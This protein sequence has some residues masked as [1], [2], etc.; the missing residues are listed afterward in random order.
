MEKWVPLMDIFLSS[1]SPEA[2]A[3]LW[4]QR[5][6]ASPASF[7]S[8]LTKPFDATVLDSSSSPSRAKRVMW[9]QTLPNAV[10]TRILSFL[11]FDHQRFSDRELSRLARNI[12]IEKPEID[13]WVKKTATNLLDIISKKDDG[14]GFSLNLKR[15]EDEFNSLPAWLKIA[16]GA[17]NLLLPWLPL[18]YDEL[19]LSSLSSPCK[20]DDTVALIETTDDEMEPGHRDEVRAAIKIVNSMNASALNSGL[21]KMAACLKELIVSSESKSKTLEIANEIRQ[22]CLDRSANDPLSLLSL[23]EPWRA[24]DEAISFLTLHLLNGIEDKV[25]WPSQILCSIILPKLLVLKEPASRVLLKTTT[26]CCKLHQRAAE[27]ALL[28]PLIL[29]SEGINNHMCDVIT[30]IIRECLHTVHVS[31]FCQKLLS[32]EED[33]WNYVCLP[34]HRHLISNELVW[35]ESL[36]N[37]F[38]NILN[39]NV[40]LTQDSVD[41]L[42]CRAHELT[43]KFSKSLKF[44]KFLLCLLTK[45]SPFLKSHKLV[46]TEAVEKTDTIMTKAILAKLASL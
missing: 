4:L 31:S 27:Y 33:D 11:A 14:T 16:A 43:G 25:V 7:L 35:T 38:Q 12:L 37:L 5:S 32:G 13:F 36:L 22:L 1:P 9:I 44:G 6:S 18:S 29:C 2:E 24:E 42:V 26:D 23:I 19:N 41:R 46:L 10:Q 45:C 17:N 40:H 8:L 20:D 30:K 3:S 39:H 34:C 21:E 15:P 28:F